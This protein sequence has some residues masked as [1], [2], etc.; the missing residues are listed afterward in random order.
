MPSINGVAFTIASTASA[1][2]QT[3]GDRMSASSGH[4]RMYRAA[5][6]HP[7][8]LWGDF[9]IDVYRACMRS[10]AGRT[11]GLHVPVSVV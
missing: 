6:K 11:N 3:N 10:A 4:S 8:Y 7:E 2:V 5:A 9:E 1:F